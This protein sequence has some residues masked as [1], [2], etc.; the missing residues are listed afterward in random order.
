LQYFREAGSER[1]DLELA[2]RRVSLLSACNSIRE[3]DSR[4]FASAVSAIIGQPLHPPHVS[5]SYQQAPEVT[6]GGTVF[7]KL[8]TIRALEGVVGVNKL[9]FLHAES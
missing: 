1:P 5:L 2:E 3:T 7:E 9:A 4:W 8:G 6:L